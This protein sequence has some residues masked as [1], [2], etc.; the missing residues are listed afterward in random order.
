MSSSPGSGCVQSNGRPKYAPIW[1]SPMWSPLVQTPLCVVP[2]V[3]L[4][5]WPLSKPPGRAGTAVL[6]REPLQSPLCQPQRVF[7]SHS[8]A[9]KSVSRGMPHISPGTCWPALHQGILQQARAE[10]GAGCSSLPCIGSSQPHGG[11][12]W[13]AWWE[14]CRSTLVLVKVRDACHC[15]IHVQT[16]PNKEAQVG[17]ELPVRAGA[18]RKG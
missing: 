18:S 13:A 16:L 1:K 5:G 14:A 17:P 7:A 4:H 6:P 11:S 3:P 12:V 9:S 15:F 2:C 8:P 10:G